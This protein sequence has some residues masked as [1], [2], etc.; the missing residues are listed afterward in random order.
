MRAYT[1]QS[2]QV[3]VVGQTVS[4]RAGESIHAD[5]SYEFIH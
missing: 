2:Q 1:I 5:H 4:V 3:R